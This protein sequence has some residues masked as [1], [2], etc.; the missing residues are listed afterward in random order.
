VAKRL[1]ANIG[2]SLCT[3]VL[4]LAR[5]RRF[6]R[7]ARDYRRAYDGKEGMEHIDIEYERKKQ[8]HHR[9]VLRAQAACVNRT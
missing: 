1:H 3:A 4:P 6:A 8:T 2:L 5:V 7:R 9:D